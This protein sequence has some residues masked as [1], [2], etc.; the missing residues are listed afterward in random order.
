MAFQRLSNYGQNLVLNL[1]WGKTATMPDTVFLAAVTE[2]PAVTDTGADLVEPTDV[3]YAR[4]EI[5]N[6]SVGTFWDE[7]TAQVKEN[8]EGLQHAQAVAEWEATPYY[9]I[10]DALSGGNLILYGEHTSPVIVGAGQTPY[11]NPGGISLTA[12]GP[13]QIEASS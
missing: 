13:I 12:V 5:D 4:L 8:L 11:I 9:A 1:M 7:A 6:S 3:N 2:L 10:C